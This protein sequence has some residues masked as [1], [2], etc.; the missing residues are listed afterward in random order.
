[1]RRTP[2][3][4]WTSAFLQRPSHTPTPDRGSEG[5]AVVGVVQLQ[6]AVDRNVAPVPGARGE[7]PVAEEAVGTGREALPASIGTDCP[8]RRVTLGGLVLLVTPLLSVDTLNRSALRVYDPDAP[9]LPHLHAL[10]RE[11]VRFTRAF[12]TASWTLPA[13]GSLFTGLYPDRHGLV[14]PERRLNDGTFKLAMLFKSAGFETVAFTGTGYLSRDY[15][16]GAGFDRYDDWAASPGWRSHLSFYRKGLADESFF[17][18]AITYLG[19]VGGENAP[20][21]LFLHTFDVHNYFKRETRAELARERPLWYCLTESM[22]C[23]E[24]DWEVLAGLYREQLVAFDAGLGLLLRTLEDEGLRDTTLLILL[25]DHGEG[26]DFGR[27][28]LPT[29]SRRRPDTAPG[30]RTRVETWIQAP[31]HTWT[32]TC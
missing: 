27:A 5:P 14:H 17:D 24:S 11:S 31:G 20:F 22:G 21:F 2:Y 15:G 26:F 19:D 32:R 6:I 12:S 30:L 7:R 25:S 1:M 13:H 3:S 4:G 9:E 28:R 10:A 16:Y 23:T 29:R 18:R 8:R